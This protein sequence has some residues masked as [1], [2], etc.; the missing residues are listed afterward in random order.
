M[1][2]KALQGFYTLSENIFALSWALNNLR[3]SLL[4][5]DRINWES[6]CRNLP[7]LR[8]LIQ[9]KDFTCDSPHTYKPLSFFQ[10]KLMSKFRLGMLHLRIETGR[11]IR[12]LPEERLCLVCNGGEVEDETHFLL[13]CNKYNLNRQKLLGEIPNLENF[14][15]LNDQDKL[16]LLLNDPTLVKKTSKFIADSFEYRS[17]II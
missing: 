17:T 3:V 8:T 4:N 13:R 14:T 10:R 11:F 2:N 6:Q 16:K 9:F 5:K 7:K 15:S 1:F 12:L